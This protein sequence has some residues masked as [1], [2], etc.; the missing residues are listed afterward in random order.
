M[1]AK[2]IQA[3]FD[4]DSK[5]RVLFF[6]DP[7]GEDKDKVLNLS[8]DDIRV[9]VFNGRWL[10]YKIKFN[11]EWEYEKV[12]FYFEMPSPKAQDE[13]SEFQLLDLLSA[14]RELALDDVEDFM[15]EYQLQPHQQSLVYK[16]R[17]E[18]TRLKVM[19][20]IRPILNASQFEEDS[21]QRGVLSF[22]LGTKNIE[23]WNIIIIRLLTY[24]LP[25]KQKNL[26]TLFNK[27][28]KVPLFDGLNRRIRNI[29]GVSIS[30]SDITEVGNLLKR[31]KYNLITQAFSAHDADP[32]KEF[33]VSDI[34]CLQAMNSLYETAI[35]DRFLSKPF[36]EAFDL[37]GK[38]IKVEKIVALYG[39]NA[40]YVYQ[41][42]DLIW[43]ILS[44]MTES[45]FAVSKEVKER[46]SS[47]KINRNEQSLLRDAV[48]FLQ[49]SIQMLSD[50]SGVESYIFDIP[51]IYLKRYAET[52]YLIDTYYRKA[53]LS[54]RKLSLEATPIDETLSSL[55][56]K[57][58]KYYFDFTF[59]LN[60]EWLKCMKEVN[61]N[62]KKIECS[63]QYDFYENNIAPLQQKVAVVISDALRYEAAVE[64]L[65]VLHSDEKN[66][67][68]LSYQLASIPSITKFGMTNL[69]PA[70]RRTYNEGDILLDAKKNASTDQRAEILNNR[71]EDSKAVAFKEV[72]ENNV[73]QNRELFKS[74]VV[75]VYHDIID[76]TG[77]KGNERDTF[78]AVET[79]VEDLAKLVNSILRS[80]NVAKVIVTSD[81]GFLYNDFDIAEVDKNVMEDSEIVESD[82]RHYITKDHEELLIGYKIPLFNVSTYEEPYYVA[83]PDAVNRFKKSGSRY[84]FTHG[85]G[86]LQE[87]V[88]PVI[89][90]TRRDESVKKKVD[91]KITTLDKDLK[92]VSN[93]LRMGIIQNNPISA[94]EKERVIEIGIYVNDSLVSETVILKLNS[95]DPKPS[96]RIQNISLVLNKS[97]VSS[98]LKLKIYDVEDKLNAIIEQNIINSTIISRDF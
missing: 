1:L 32:Y 87:L 45:D 80:F 98:V 79:A 15:T 12:F 90:C 47:L 7:Q 18:L 70:R 85:G 78:R 17:S 61:F 49:D 57:I 3:A 66:I 44:K 24:S 52:F 25:E 34:S 5:L 74:N 50:I 64:L 21:I 29:F 40:D 58:D 46:L 9:E 86:S 11:K 53:V 42:E 13:L 95:T 43:E 81:H 84:R 37:H 51:E 75:Y 33:K 71:K 68:Y 6:F 28:S 48:L 30:D 67:S 22:H 19:Q 94:S 69:L 62:Y 60:N 59:R 96:N 39:Y 4:R 27:F 83:I 2:K 92:V 20:V 97:T 63:K 16:Y 65:G 10:D 8:F 23:D 82:A 73:Q 31:L 93:T 76:K 77:H 35:H 91:F 72:S 56:N 54:Y 14:N 26:N 55:K 88:V 41:T 89:E 36:I 38:A